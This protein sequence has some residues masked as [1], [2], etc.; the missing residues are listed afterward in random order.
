MNSLL[1]LLATSTLSSLLALGASDDGSFGK[2]LDQLLADKLHVE[3]LLAP[4]FVDFLLL[5]FEGVFLH[6][7]SLLLG[8]FIEVLVSELSIFIT[9]VESFFPFHESVLIVLSFVASQ[10]SLNVAGSLHS[11]VVEAEF[12]IN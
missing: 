9:H 11:E 10:E 7:V 3:F 12:K 1:F 5:L 4:F 6:A 2:L 8:S